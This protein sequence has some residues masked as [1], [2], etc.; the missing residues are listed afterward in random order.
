MKYSIREKKI[1]LRY[2]ILYTLFPIITVIVRVAIPSEIIFDF[3][4][5]GNARS[6]FVKRC[7]FAPVDKLKLKLRIIVR[8]VRNNLE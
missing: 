5:S 4:D 6:V 2:L 3:C 7:F 8:N 1:L